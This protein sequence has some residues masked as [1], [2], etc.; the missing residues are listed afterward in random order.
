MCYSRRFRLTIFVLLVSGSVALAQKEQQ[1]A[2]PTATPRSTAASSPTATANPAP[3]PET[4]IDAK[5]EAELLQA[6][7]RFVNAIRN[8]DVKE[9][10]EILHPQYADA[11]EG[12]EKAFIK[13]AVIKRASEGQLPAYRVARERKLTRSGNLFTVE[14]LANNVAQELSEDA[15]TEKWASVRRVWT[16]ENGRWIATAQI[17]KEL[18]E[19]EARQKL[20]PEKEE[21]KPN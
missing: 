13:R 12:S 4:K 5:M 3:T 21:K 17:V 1:P 9:L 10:E 14:G 7:D 11:M 15:P 19:N 8:R 16:K 2:K 18:E 6:E 20:A